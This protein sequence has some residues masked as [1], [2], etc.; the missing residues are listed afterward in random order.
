VDRVTS[1]FGP[2]PSRAAERKAA[3]NANFRIGCEARG[4]T[5]LASIRAFCSTAVAFCRCLALP[6][7][8]RLMTKVVKGGC[9][10][11]DFG[12]S[13]GYGLAIAPIKWRAVTNLKRS[14]VSISDI[15][16]KLSAKPNARLLNLLIRQ[17]PYEGFVMEVNDI[18]PVAEWV[19]EST[20]KSW[21]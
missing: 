18:N 9:G 2:Q 3:I 13:C 15:R 4:E 20:P 10:K 21:D 1:V 6:K 16:A 19:P 12:E 7:N 17:K 14:R 5:N 11:V 8:H